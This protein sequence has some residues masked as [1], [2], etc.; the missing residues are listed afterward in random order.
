MTEES[1]QESRLRRYLSNPWVGFLGI[2]LASINIAGMFIIFSLSRERRDLTYLVNPERNVVFRSGVTSALRVL[3]E[4]REIKKD[5]TAV[6]V[7]VWNAGRKPIKKEH[8]LAVARIVTKPAAHILEAR[9]QKVSRDVVGLA[10][11][12]AN[13]NDGWISLSWR[14]LERND[15]GV[16]QLIF[17]GPP[18]TEVVVEAVVQEQGPITRLQPSEPTKWPTMLLSVVGIVFIV[19]SLTVLSVVGHLRH[20]SREGQLRMWA[21]WLPLL[22]LSITL[23]NVIAI[24]V[25]IVMRSFGITGPPLGF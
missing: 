3:H 15:G 23:L 9:I 21:A 6:Q 12:D 7:E 4:Q 20:K 10:I 16:I 18:D 8:V 2:L 17:E 11:D 19:L 22:G 14:I 1:H 24:M 13:A 25:F 5:V